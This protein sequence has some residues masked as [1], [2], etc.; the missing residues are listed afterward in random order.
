MLWCC[1]GKGSQ[2][3]LVAVAG[4]GREIAHEFEECS[5]RPTVEGVCADVCTYM[6]WSLCSKITPGRCLFHSRPVHRG[7]R[8]TAGE[9][10]NVSL[11]QAGQGKFQV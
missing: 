11:K 9:S 4:A 6:Y 2:R 10:N 8:L 1:P 5:N 7:S 3:A